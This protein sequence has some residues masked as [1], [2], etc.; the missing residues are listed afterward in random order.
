MGTNAKNSGNN[1][2]LKEAYETKYI[3]EGIQNSI[4]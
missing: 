4:V 1:T 3:D 2:G